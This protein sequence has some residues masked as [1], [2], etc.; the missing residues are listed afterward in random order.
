VV[1]DDD[2]TPAVR[3]P[4]RP[5]QQLFLDNPDWIRRTFEDHERREEFRRNIA[6]TDSDATQPMDIPG[7]RLGRRNAIS[8]PTLFA[9]ENDVPVGGP[10]RSPGIME[11]TATPVTAGLLR[12]Q[13]HGVAPPTF[14][15]R[16]INGFRRPLPDNVARFNVIRGR[17]EVH[18]ATRRVSQS[19][20]I[21]QGDAASDEPEEDA[22]ETSSR[23]GASPENLGFDNDDTTNEQLLSAVL[24]GPRHQDPEVHMVLH[25]PD[26]VPRPCQKKSVPR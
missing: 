26:R 1:Q 3:R 5:M 17:F 7:A 21:E 9:N 18:E 2:D 24:S 10:P 22:Y 23:M 12:A 25:V 19:A 11:R 16:R 20:T 13:R 8:G 6:N 14:R 15:R 4:L